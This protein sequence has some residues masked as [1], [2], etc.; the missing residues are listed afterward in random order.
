MKF[1]Q[2]SSI[3]LILCTLMF[4][5]FTFV[6]K[7]LQHLLENNQLLYSLHC[8]LLTSHVL[9]AIQVHLQDQSLSKLLQIKTICLANKI[10]QNKTGLS[11]YKS[12][13]EGL[14]GEVRQHQNTIWFNNLQYR[15]TNTWALREVS[16]HFEYLENLSCGLV[17]IWRPVRRHLTVHP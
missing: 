12:K 7:Q 1:I 14:A 8:L 17:V 10:V 15:H 9:I 4:V 6:R 3:F 13:F 2:T 5:F 11:V 16:S